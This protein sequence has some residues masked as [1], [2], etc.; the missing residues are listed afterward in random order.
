MD[1]QCTSSQVSFS[2][3]PLQL[4]LLEFNQQYLKLYS[5]DNIH[6]AHMI[7]FMQLSSNSCGLYWS[8][9]H[10]R[11]KPFVLQSFSDWCHSHRAGHSEFWYV[12]LQHT[13]G[14]SMLASLLVQ[15]S[16]WSFVSTNKRTIGVLISE[17]DTT[18]FAGTPALRTSSSFFRFVQFGSRLDGRLRSFPCRWRLYLRGCGAGRPIHL[19]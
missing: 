2:V 7:M 19:L 15:I 11:N 10:Q 16:G 5:L 1:L 13:R 8:H 6:F 17:G 9:L 4:H 18:C 3:K 14:F 12:F